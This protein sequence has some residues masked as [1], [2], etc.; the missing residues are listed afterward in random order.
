MDVTP[1]MICVFVVMCC[2][3]LVLLYYFY[4]HLGEPCSGWWLGAGCGW[5]STPHF[6]PSPCS[7]R[8]HWDLLPGLLHRP[9]QLPGTLCASPALLWVQVSP[10]PEVPAPSY[11]Q[12]PSPVLLP[13]FQPFGHSSGHSSGH[14]ASTPQCWP[15]AEPISGPSHQ[16]ASL[17]P[18][19]CPAAIW[20]DAGP[21]GPL[22]QP[23][24]GSRGPWVA[25]GAADWPCSEYP[26]GQGPGESPA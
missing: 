24:Q 4:D 14:R 8:H 19:S 23:S 22:P 11:S 21:Q 18:A 20:G 16:A 12:G 2:S 3:M 6:H 13:G 26:T 1:V 5:G 15:R 17:S 9:L 7:L 25:T 10:A